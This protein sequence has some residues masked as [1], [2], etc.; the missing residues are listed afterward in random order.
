MASPG[1]SQ[2]PRRAAGAASRGPHPALLSPETLGADPAVRRSEGP[3]GAHVV[4]RLDTYRSLEQRILQGKALARELTCVTRPALGLPN[5]L[6]PGKE[7]KRGQDGAGGRI[8]L[9]GPGARSEAPSLPRINHAGSSEA[10]WQCGGFR[11]RSLQH[12]VP[13][14]GTSVLE[15][16]WRGS[17]PG[18]VASTALLCWAGDSSS[19]GA[20]GCRC[21]SST[22]SCTLL[23]QVPGCTG[24]GHLWGSASTLHRVLEEC[25]SLLTTFWSTVLPV[26]PAQHQGKVSTVLGAGGAIGLDACH[27]RHS[28]RPRSRLY[29][30]RSRRCVPSSLRRRMPC[31]ARLSNS[32]AWPGS[33]TA[34]SSSS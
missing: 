32:A 23:P 9:C 26:S 13:V 29:R 4:G 30:V 22:H 2:A 10:R 25:A 34:W 18:A 12:G 5:H 7:V 11:A 24:A 3:T 8:L 16:Y 17:S 27:S 6:L 1:Q 33:R 21:P 20:A 15:A 28:S 31:R 19:L 14:A